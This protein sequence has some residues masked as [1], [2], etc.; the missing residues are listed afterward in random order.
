M[1]G[2][3]VGVV[4]E[5]N[6]WWRGWDGGGAGMVEELNGWWRGGGGGGGEWM[7]EGRGWR[8]RGDGGGGGGVERGRAACRGRVKGWQVAVDRDT[9]HL[10]TSCGSCAH[11]H[12]HAFPCCIDS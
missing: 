7:V 9:D 6:G 1:D 3:G 11:M 12:Y 8:R 2:G 5:L 10:E 4:E